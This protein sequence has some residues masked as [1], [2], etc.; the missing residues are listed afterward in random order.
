MEVRSYNINAG[1]IFQQ[2]ASA[3]RNVIWPRSQKKNNNNIQK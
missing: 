2:Y 1:G 3:F